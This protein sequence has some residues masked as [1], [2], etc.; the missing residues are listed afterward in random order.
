MHLW[1][2]DLQT[3]SGKD[4]R[5][6]IYELHLWKKASKN[7][8]FALWLLVLFIYLFSQFFNSV[9]YIIGGRVFTLND[10]ENGVLRSNRKP[11]GAFKRPFSRDDPR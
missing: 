1:F 6:E 8:Y 7:M 4:L 5:W 10:I 2:R 3:V 9:S 11:I